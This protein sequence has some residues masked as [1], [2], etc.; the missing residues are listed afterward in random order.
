MRLDDREPWVVDLL[1][2]DDDSRPGEG[3]TGA[4]VVAE[5]VLLPRVEVHVLE[6][7]IAG[8]SHVAYATITP[9]R[10]GREPLRQMANQ[11]VLT[12]CEPAQR[13][14]YDAWSYVGC[15]LAMDM[16]PAERR[17]S[18]WRMPGEPDAPQEV[19]LVV[20]DGQGVPDQAMIDAAP[21][22]AA[23]PRRRGN[24]FLDTVRLVQ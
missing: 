19:R 1:E 5:H 6:G 18:A 2:V 17:V 13:D 20:V 21:V 24:R 14:P 15:G 12:P 10:Y 3:T 11:L 16:R 23:P 8:A 22:L 9:R 4:R 7:T